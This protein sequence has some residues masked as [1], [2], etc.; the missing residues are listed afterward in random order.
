MKEDYGAW[1]LFQTTN[2]YWTSTNHVSDIVLAFETHPCNSHP[3]YSRETSK[4]QH[5]IVRIDRRGTS[6][7]W[8]GPSLVVL[9]CIWKQVEKAMGTSQCAGLLHG[10]CISSYLQVSALCEFLSWL[11][12]MMNNTGKCNLCKPFPPQLLCWFCHSNGNPKTQAKALY[13]M[14]GCAGCFLPTRHKLRSSGKREP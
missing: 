14:E 10:L 12:P 2:I 11:P 9:S 3:Y 4:E 1:S 8:V 5:G 7:W 13:A 6:S